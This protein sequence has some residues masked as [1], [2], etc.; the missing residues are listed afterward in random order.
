MSDHRTGD[1]HVRT[2][3]SY[4]SH[5]QKSLISKETGLH[6]ANFLQLVSTRP[7]PVLAIPCG[8]SFLQCVSPKPRTDT[9]GMNA[10]QGQVQQGESTWAKSFWQS[11]WLRG[12]G[13]PLESLAP[14]YTH[15]RREALGGLTQTPSSQANSILFAVGCWEPR[16]SQLEPSFNYFSIIMSLTQRAFINLAFPS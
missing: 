13:G 6:P 11:R 9:N 3:L 14:G 16:R 1:L 5:K 7:C 8:P 10:S 2:R 15:Q 12:G 4:H